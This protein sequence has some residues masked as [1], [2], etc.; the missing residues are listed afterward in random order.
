MKKILAVSG[1]VDSMSMLDIFVRQFPKSDLVVATFDHGTRETSEEDV[2]FVSGIC[3]ALEIPVYRGKAD[4]GANV[5][6]EK[7]RTAR[8]DFLRKV[9]FEEHG[10]I[11]TAHHLDDL[12]ETI[13]INFLRGT[14]FRGLACF[15]ALG[16]RRPFLDDLLNPQDFKLKAFDKNSILTY[17]A[18][19][20]IV[21]REDPTNETDD[22]L[23]N[24]VRKTTRSLPLSKKLKIYE[25]WKNQKNLVREINNLTESLI[26]E[27][28]KF[29]R[30]DFLELDD[31]TAL[32]I[33]RSALLRAGI[34]TTIPQRKDF[35]NAIHTYEPGKTFNLPKDRLVKINKKDFML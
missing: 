3:S 17:A 26:P 35:L 27:D 21:F 16:V 1:G 5:S 2:R 29:A 6:E 22:Y 34:S 8:Y 12:V 30:A 13:T 32:E 24:R 33:L 4:L 15:S 14:D 28:L 23:R 11:Y 31:K 25:L 7:A 19:N 9:A 18:K 10:E 20:S